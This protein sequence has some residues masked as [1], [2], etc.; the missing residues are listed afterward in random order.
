MTSTSIHTTQE[1]MVHFQGTHVDDD[2]PIYWILIRAG[3]DDVTIHLPKEHW[4]SFKAKF[5]GDD[6]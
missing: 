4:E 3:N 2:D 1:P 6:E 5:G